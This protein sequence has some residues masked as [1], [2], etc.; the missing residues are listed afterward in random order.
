[1]A[2]DR[3]QLAR[4]QPTLRVY[5]RISTNTT[6]DTFGTPT[7]VTSATYSLSDTDYVTGD[8]RRCIFLWEDD[9]CYYAANSI[10]GGSPN[11]TWKWGKLDLSGTGIT[12]TQDDPYGPVIVPKSGLLPTTLTLTVTKV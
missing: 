8:E 3:W 2:A 5:R 10:V 1:M 6:D 7:K 12:I 11:D 9:W 4:Q